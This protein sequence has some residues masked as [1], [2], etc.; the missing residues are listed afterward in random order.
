MI[1]IPERPLSAPRRHLRVIGTQSFDLAG[2][3]AAPGRGR[4]NVEAQRNG[5]GHGRAAGALFRVQ[6]ESVGANG[7]TLSGHRHS[8]GGTGR[9]LDL[10]CAGKGEGVES[11]VVD[12]ASIATSRRRSRRVKTDRIDGEALLRALMAYKRGEPRVCA[13]VRAPTPEDEDDRR[14]CRERKTLNHRACPARQSDQRP[15][16]LP[17]R[18]GL[19]AA[20]P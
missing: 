19:R 11:W 1:T 10:P 12:P 14:L 18:I 4:E 13:M 20:A 2:H 17:R 16:V 5:W 6:T 8:G 9:V 7:K 3:I 15:A